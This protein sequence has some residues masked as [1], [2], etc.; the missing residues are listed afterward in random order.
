MPVE[1]GIEERNTADD[2]VCARVA[3]AAVVRPQQGEFASE[4]N[5]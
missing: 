2:S 5:T 4:R 1:A 3:A